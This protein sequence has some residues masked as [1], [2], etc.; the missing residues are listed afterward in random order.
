MP[1]VQYYKHSFFSNH[2]Q[3]N[4]S[5]FKVIAQDSKQS[6]RETREAIHIRI[7]NITLNYNTEKKYI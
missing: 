7:N 4:I 2:P 5:H 3:A 1:P 6:V